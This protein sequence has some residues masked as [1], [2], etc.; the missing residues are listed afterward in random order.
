MAVVDNYEASNMQVMRE[1]LARAEARTK[2]V[3]AFTV[4][5]FITT[6]VL[7]ALAVIAVADFFNTVEETKCE[8]SKPLNETMKSG[9]QLM[10]ALSNN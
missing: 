8:Q 5:V 3:A 7:A 6:N 4:V 9:R 2:V 1:K 10:L